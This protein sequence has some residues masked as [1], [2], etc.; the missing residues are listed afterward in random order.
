MKFEK[1][2][3]IMPNLVKLNLSL[4]ENDLHQ[5]F[6]KLRSI[7]YEENVYRNGPLFYKISEDDKNNPVRNIEFYM[8]ISEIP[9]NFPYETIELLKI[10]DSIEM[11]QADLEPN[12]TTVRE[13][14]AM[15]A[16]ETYARKLGSEMY[17]VYIDLYNEVLIDVYIPMV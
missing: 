10:D 17:C 15:Y 5:G 12:L 4:N 16:Q 8:P 2:P 14:I 3:L 6:D 9:E 7:E 11:R 1:I 13:K